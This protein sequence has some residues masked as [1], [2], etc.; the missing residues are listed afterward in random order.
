MTE[1]HAQA[2]EYLNA[3]QFALSELVMAKHYALHPEL[4]RPYG[5]VGRIRCREDAAF[6]LSFLAQALATGVP[7]LFVDYIAW[8]KVM[9]GSRR[10]TALDLAQNMEVLRAVLNDRLPSELASAALEYVDAGFRALPSLATDSPTL[11]QTDAPLANIAQEYMSAL[12]RFD[13]AVAYTTIVDAVNGGTSIRDIYEHVFARVQREI[14]R[15]WQ[16]NKLTVAEEHYCTAATQLVI[17][18]LYPRIFNSHRNGRVMVGMCTTGDLHEIGVRMV[19]D[20]F[21]MEGWDTTYLGANVPISSA[22]QMVR[23]RRPEVLAVSATIPFHVTATKNLINAVRNEPELEH[24]RILVGGYA[25]R[26]PDLWRAV[27]ADAYGR[28]AMEAIELGDSMLR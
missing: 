21:E 20:F 11:M 22:V 18:Q 6:H 15:L 1:T 25:F 16:V 24:V 8:A 14:G 19:C 7:E 4:G 12:L 10:V 9:L 2:A 3:N 5:P 27:G 23:L 13:R 26:V 28:N 17:S